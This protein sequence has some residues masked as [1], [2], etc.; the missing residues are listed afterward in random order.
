MAEGVGVL[1]VDIDGERLKD[2]AAAG[3]ETMT[4]DLADPAARERLAEAGTDYDY[5]VNAAGIILLKPI[6]DVSVEDWRR[7][8]TINAESIFFLCQKL[9]PRLRAGGA[10]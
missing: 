1:A 6:F 3:A 10:I 8:Q 7:V 4:A 9:G 5:L 2:L